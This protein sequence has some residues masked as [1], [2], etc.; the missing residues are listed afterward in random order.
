MFEKVAYM[1]VNSKYVQKFYRVNSKISIPLRSEILSDYWKEIFGTVKSVGVRNKDET[2][3][4]IIMAESFLH[5]ITS[6]ENRVQVN[7]FEFNLLFKYFSGARFKF[8]EV[9]K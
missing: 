6:I 4:C 9:K 3:E 1:Y 7:C 2:H 8:S 5:L